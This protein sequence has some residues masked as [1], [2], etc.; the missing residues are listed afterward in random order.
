MAVWLSWLI[1]RAYPRSRGG[2]RSFGA[3]PSGWT[4]LSPLARGNP[5]IAVAGYAPA[6]PIPARAGEP[7]LMPVNVAGARAYPRSRGGTTSI[8]TGI[9]ALAGLSPLARGNRRLGDCRPYPQGPI[10][11]RA[12]EPSILIILP[13]PLWAYPRSRGGT[14]ETDLA[15]IEQQGLSPLARRNLHGGGKHERLRGPIPARAGEPRGRAFRDTAN[16]AYPRSRGGTG[17]SH[18]EFIASLGLSPLARGNLHRP[19][20]AGISCG[21]IPARAGEPKI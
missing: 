1:L 8:S 10:P 18:P 4:G 5:A 21:P 7:Y 9:A 19:H 11:A 15:K 6:G 12:G 20:R 17:K 16:G 13:I 14:H 2:T 3:A